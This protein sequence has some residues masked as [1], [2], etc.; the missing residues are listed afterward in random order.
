MRLLA[1]FATALLGW[2]SLEAAPRRVVTVA[3]FPHAPALSMG[4]NGVAR[5]F[6]ADMLREVAAREDWE[7]RFLPGT[8]QEGLD[9]LRAGQA[10]LHTSVAF[11]SARAL[12]LDYGKESSFT[13]WS[14]LYSH[15]K[16][17]IHTVLDVLN[18]RIGLMR[19]DVNGDHFREL[20]AKFNLQVT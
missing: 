16:A 20:V 19:G 2:V 14:I 17:A 7:L 4:E 18:R 13:V 10:D 5:G 11:T 12:Y 3:V 1:I 6:Y 15:P 8:F 9:R